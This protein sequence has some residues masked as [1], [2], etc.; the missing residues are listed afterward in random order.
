MKLAKILSLIVLLFVAIDARAAKPN[1]LIILADD[2]THNDLPVYGGENAKTPNLD[3]LASQGVTFNRA[4]L[5]EAMCQPCRAELYSGLYPMRNGCAWNHSSSH[6]DI[7]SMPHYLGEAGYRVGLAGKVHVLPEQAFPFESIGGYDNN[8]VRDPT[9]EH[10]IAPATEFVSRSDDPFCLVVALVEPHVPWVMGDASAYPPRSLKLPPNIA[11]T[12]ETRRAFGRYLAEITYMDSQVGE[13][14]AMLDASGKADN[15]LVLFSSEQGSQFPGNKWTNYNTGVHTAMIARLP[16]I[17]EPGRRTDAIVQYAD[18]LPTLLDLSGTQYE[19]GA[20]DGT[21]FAS[22]LRG[23]TD[24]HRNYVYGVHNNVPEGPPY[25]IRSICDG[26]YH[27][28][29]NLQNQNLYIEKHLM[30]IQGDGKLNNLYWQT[31]VFD[32]F[33]NPDAYRLIQR[34][35]SRPPEELFDLENDPYEMNNLAGSASVEAI[36]KE[37]SLKLDQWLQSQGDPGIDQ[38]TREALQAAKKGEHLYRSPSR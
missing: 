25:P 36:Q 35:Q 8:C 31:W 37:L 21:S 26:R 3:Q 13:L 5:A 4:F 24:E 7:R 23:T 9:K 6:K 2:C 12:P 29:R 28:I 27:Y 10:E 30:G 18:V 20:F 11:D 17:T 22:V 34:Y 19:P 33:A 14:M 1:V 32:S 16:G 15:T 38:D